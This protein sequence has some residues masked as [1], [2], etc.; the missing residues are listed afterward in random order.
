MQ[1]ELYDSGNETSMQSSDE[2][3]LPEQGPHSNPLGIEV[4]HHTYSTVSTHAVVTITHPANAW[5]L[6][7]QCEATIT[8]ETTHSHSNALRR[9]HG[10]PTNHAPRRAR[11]NSRVYRCCI[12]YG[13]CMGVCVCVCVICCRVLCISCICCLWRASW[14]VSVRHCHI[15]YSIAL[16][17]LSCMW[18]CKHA[19]MCVC[20]WISTYVRRYVCTYVRVGVCMWCCMRVCM[21]VCMWMYICMTV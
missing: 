8:P 6:K 7:L 12:M 13:V 17:W 14:A 15:L 21:C 16:Y 10:V 20:R 5:P 4:E 9:T 3:T 11:S 18:V 19:A 1:D 2:S